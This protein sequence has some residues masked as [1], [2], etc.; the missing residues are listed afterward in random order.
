MYLAPFVTPGPDR[1]KAELVPRMKERRPPAYSLYS[2]TKELGRA[3][4]PGPKYNIPTTIGPK[5]P[6]MHAAGAYTM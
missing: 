2:R 1:Y 5:V 4:Y 6:D 3:E